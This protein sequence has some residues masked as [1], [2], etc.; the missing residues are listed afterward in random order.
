[1][2]RLVAL[3]AKQLN[4]QNFSKPKVVYV[5]DDA[6]M[7]IVP[8]IKS[9]RGCRVVEKKQNATNVYVVYET[10]MQIEA[11]RNLA[12][13]DTLVKQHIALALAGVGTTQGAGLVLTKFFNEATTI[14]A[15]ATEAFV[16]PAATVGKVV[17]FCNNDVVADA[18]KVFPAVG[19]FIN[20][21]AVNTV[22]SIPGQQTKH[23]VCLVLGK[24]T[25]ADDFGRP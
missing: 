4:G 11:A 13:T 25:V 14:G 12:S 9:G 1:M 6:I 3:T 18:A 16:L 5:N 20:S 10:A 23:F 24:W 22:L 2:G 21:Q 7:A 17:Q 8:S 19:E 15:A